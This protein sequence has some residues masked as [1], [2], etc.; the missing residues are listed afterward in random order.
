MSSWCGSD[1]SRWLIVLS[2]NCICNDGILFDKLFDDLLLIN[3]DARG[4]GSSEKGCS[5]FFFGRNDWLVRW[6]RGWSTTGKSTQS[7]GQRHT[8]L[9]NCRCVHDRYWWYCTAYR[10]GG[11]C[12]GGSHRRCRGRSLELLKRLWKCNVIAW[13]LFMRILNGGMNSKSSKSNDTKYFS[14]LFKF[15]SESSYAH[16]FLHFYIRL[17]L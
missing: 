9:F 17:V 8:G 3:D 1:K 11:G 12:V 15:D 4:F 13:S 2:Y 14:S 10:W 6:Y 5:H 7:S 16:V